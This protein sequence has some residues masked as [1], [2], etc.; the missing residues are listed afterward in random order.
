MKRSYVILGWLENWVIYQKLR[1]HRY[2]F[3]IYLQQ[4]MLYTYRVIPFDNQIL[5][6]FIYLP[7]KKLV[8]N[9]VLLL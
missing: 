6:L 5:K 9:V 3:T 1:R 2:V 7:P 4:S 8:A